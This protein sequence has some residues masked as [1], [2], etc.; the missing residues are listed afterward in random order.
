M[1]KGKQTHSTSS[2]HTWLL[3]YRCRC[4]M[5]AEGLH[6][7][8]FCYLLFPAPLKGAIRGRWKSY[9]PGWRRGRRVRHQDSGWGRGKWQR[10]KLLWKHHNNYVF[11]AAIDTVNIAISYVYSLYWIL[12]LYVQTSNQSVFLLHAMANH[13]EVQE[14][15]YEELRSVLGDSN[16]ITSEH[17]SQLPY[18][19]G[20]MPESFRWVCRL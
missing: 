16:Y 3:L 10:K 12:H 13:P 17:L 8:A 14:R 19:K 18:L 4:I 7:S 9:A 6:F 2:G 1:A 15:L 11:A 20:C 5:C